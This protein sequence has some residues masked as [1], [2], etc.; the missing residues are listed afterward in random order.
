MPY[1][2]NQGKQEIKQH[3][4]REIPFNTY[5][6]DC[7]AGCGTYSDLL[8][9]LYKNIDGI[10]IFQPYVDMF[11]LEDKYK[12]L[13][14]QDVLTFDFSRYGYAIFGDIIEH[15]SVENAQIL[16]SR[17]HQEGIKIMVAV[18]FL[19]EQGTYLNNLNETH[20][21]SDL[22]HEIF[23]KRYPMFNAF[24]KDERYGYYLNY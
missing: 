19:F 17:L 18:P 14:V 10:E 24:W 6:I 22:T 5:I 13:F 8:R 21:Q 9:M 16:L 1:S 12:R 15:L 23:L 3:F 7:G 11:N 4:I 20:L 2:Y